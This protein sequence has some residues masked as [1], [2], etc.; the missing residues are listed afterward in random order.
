MGRRI[1]IHGDDGNVYAL[2]EDSL[3]QHKVEDA[4]AE[5]LRAEFDP[6]HVE[7][8]LRGKP[9]TMICAMAEGETQ[10]LCAMAHGAR[11]MIC[12]RGSADTAMICSRVDS[13]PLCSRADGDVYLD[14]RRAKG[15]GDDPGDS[16][17]GGGGTS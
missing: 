17:V 14:L 10:P 7:S 1:I 16:D 11:T 3:Q 4:E 15:G 9:H 6:E 8:L 13:E 5:G 2:D 12:G